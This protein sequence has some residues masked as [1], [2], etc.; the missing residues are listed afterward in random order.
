MARMNCEHCIWNSSQL[1]AVGAPFIRVSL[2]PFLTLY[3]FWGSEHKSGG[4]CAYS[5]VIFATPLEHMSLGDLASDYYYL[6]CGGR[7]AFSSYAA[8]CAAWLILTMLSLLCLADW[9][10]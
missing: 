8:V 1:E 6:H 2:F 9:V 10:D 7:K 5:Q 3:C 4:S